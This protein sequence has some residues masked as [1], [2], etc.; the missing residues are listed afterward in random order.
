MS[1]RQKHNRIAALV[2]ATSVVVACGGAV[3]EPTSQARDG[4]TAEPALGAVAAGNSAEAVA[5]INAQ[6]E[7]WTGLAEAHTRAQV[8][9]ARWNAI[10]AHAQAQASL[11]QIVGDGSSQFAESKRLNSLKPV[12][13]TSQQVAEQARFDSLRPTSDGSWE[14]AE[15]RAM[16]NAAG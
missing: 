8:E 5:G 10:A 1:H 15:F 3:V 16:T 6:T 11:A 2:V 4:A 7:R 9:T 13:D 14:E 12:G